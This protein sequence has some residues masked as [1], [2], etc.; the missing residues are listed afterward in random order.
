MDSYAFHFGQVNDRKKNGLCGFERGLIC[1]GR[2]ICNFMSLFKM[3]DL[4]ERTNASSLVRQIGG[5]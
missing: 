3:Q 5:K 2:N 4:L 1:I